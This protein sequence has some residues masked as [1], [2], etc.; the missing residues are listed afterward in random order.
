MNSLPNQSNPIKTQDYK[1]DK[2]QI[3]A[4]KERQLK[5]GTD[6]DITDITINN[7]MPNGARTSHRI[8][9]NRPNPTDTN[10][11]LPSGE[12]KEEHK[13]KRQINAN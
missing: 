4:T 1:L 7:I 12:D 2:Q 6:T 5:P 3:E 9:F 10:E 8:V 11:Y 13:E